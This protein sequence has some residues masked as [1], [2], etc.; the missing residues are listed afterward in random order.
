MKNS[1]W[2]IGIV[3][4]I[5]VVSVSLV[6]ISRKPQQ[7][8]STTI[9][10]VGYLPSLAASPMYAAI[11][12]GNF[13]AEGL[14]VKIQEVYSGPELINTLQA[15]AVDI[16][17]GIV[18]PLVL[19]RSKGLPIKSIVGATIDSGE[20]R[21]HRFMLPPD[22]DIKKGS[23][24]KGKKIA[25]VARGTSDYFGLL[26]YLNKHGLSEGDVKIIK[27]PHPEMIF[28]VSSGSIDA[29]C[30]I[31]P[32]I[33]IGKLKGRI[34][35][36]DF[37]YPEEPIEIGTY[38]AHEDFINQ[39]PEVVRRFRNAIKKGNKFCSNHE[40]LRQ[41]LPKL[42]NY[43]I[44]FKISSEVAQNLNIMEFHDSL[45][46]SGVKKIMDQLLE[47]DILKQPI[48]IKECINKAD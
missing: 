30:G 1:K 24:L 20:I 21:E 17:F 26:Q 23:D 27:M 15:K 25:V 4:A 44:K 32:F 13:E 5:I 14:N 8:T 2:I 33:T 19:S 35:V 3:I 7:Q 46:V 16:A 22:S 39:S 29:A 28:A 43:G 40:Q 9:V 47:H 12:N 34:K 10:R 48:D 41:L 11:A 6:L 31:E 36:F 18:P 38:L 45:T 42:E 37:Y